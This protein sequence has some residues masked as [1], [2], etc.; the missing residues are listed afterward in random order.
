MD[1]LNGPLLAV[2][3]FL[4]QY[5]LVGG[6]YTAIVRLLFP[7][8]AFLILF[9]A[10]RSLLSI[11]HT[12]EVWGQL[13]LPNG[14]AI[15]LNH[16]ENIIGRGASADV[17]LAYPSISRQHAALC[18]GEKDQWTVYDLGSKGGTRVNGE[19]VEGSAPVALGD[20]ITLGG[21]DL[22]FLPQTVAEQE[23]MDLRRQAERPTAIW[24]S[25]VWLTIFQ[26]LTCLQLIIALG[27]EV[28]YA[29]PLAFLG[30]TAV[31]L[32]YCPAADPL[33]GL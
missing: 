18:R 33:R 26:V 17:R 9:R 12:P 16:W 25:F 14:S 19:A 29:V 20:T 15:T 6:W 27:E 31:G 2:A 10:V 1:L 23:Q 13:S 22:I 8:L 11:P 30:L 7:I 5:P 4:D 21:V 32:F 28:T 3:T 24:P